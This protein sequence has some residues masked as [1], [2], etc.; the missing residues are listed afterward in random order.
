[1]PTVFVTGAASG[2]GRA[3]VLRLAGR[4]HRIHAFDVDADGLSS[5]PATVE[6]HVGDVTD[7]ERVRAVLPTD[8]DALVNCAATYELGAVEDADW[9]DVEDQFRV[10]VFGTL[11]V[12]RTALPVLRA[13]DGRVVTLSSVLGRASLPL[14]GVYAGTKH[15]LEGVFDALRAEQDDVDVVLVEPGAVKTGFNERAK[16]GLDDEQSPHRDLYDRVSDHY[17]PGGVPPERVARVVVEAVESPT[18]KARYPVTGQA[19]LLLA[20]RTLLPERLYDRVVLARV[21]NRSVFRASL[22]LVTSAV[23]Q[24]FVRALGRR[25]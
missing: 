23:S 6:T 4:G 1:M 18:P 10:N 9:D 16:A 19:W 20:C 2:I 21:R 7:E 12:T 5:L 25:R 3:T 15:A 22:E 11:A 8:L 24:R 17:D 13:N 14:H